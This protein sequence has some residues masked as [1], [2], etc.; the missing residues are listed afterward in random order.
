MST[1][2]IDKIDKMGAGLGDVE[3]IRGDGLSLKLPSNDRTLEVVGDGCSI[4]LP[5][6]SGIVRVIG[7]GCRLRIDSNVGDVEYVGDGGRVLLGS[8]S[9]KRNVKYVGDGGKVSVDGDKR[10]SKKVDHVAKGKI[11]KN[12]DDGSKE[13]M[14]GSCKTIEEEDNHLNMKEEAKSAGR[15]KEGKLVKIVTVLH[16]DERVVSRWFVDP[17]SV[18]RSLDGKFAK[19]ESKRKEKS[20]GDR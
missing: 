16:C 7:D 11:G 10:R 20:K 3:R 17:G 9:S 14:R 12:G 4:I 15:K 18:V 8:K 19:V 13:K 1:D 6:N 2:K 5:G